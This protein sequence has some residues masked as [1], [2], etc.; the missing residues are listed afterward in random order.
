MWGGCAGLLAC[1]WVGAVGYLLLGVVGAGVVPLLYPAVRWYMVVVCFLSAPVFSVRPFLCPCCTLPRRQVVHGSGLL[2][3]RPS[4][5]CALCLC[6][7]HPQRC[8]VWLEVS[9]HRAAVLSAWARLCLG[10]RHVWSP[11]TLMRHVAMR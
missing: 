3:Q 9:H 4:L 6:S 2:S 7:P 1:R 5:L 10:P 8:R 11:C